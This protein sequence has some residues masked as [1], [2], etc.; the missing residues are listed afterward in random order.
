MIQKF[1]GLLIL[2][3]LGFVIGTSSVVVS[4]AQA[5]FYVSGNAGV[6]TL[7]DS[8]TKWDGDLGESTFNDGHV[9]TGA[10]GHTWGLFRVEGELSYRKNDWVVF[11]EEGLAYA[12]EGDFSSLSFMANVWRDFNTGT[13]YVPFVGGGIGISTMN[14]EI[15]KIENSPLSYDISDTVF[16]YQLGAGIGYKLT[17]KATINLSYRLFG[18]SE[19]ELVDSNNNDTYEYLNHSFMIGYRTTF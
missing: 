12:T 19:V 11:I 3:V 4:K 17:P 9:F 2:S 6:S 7:M 15:T 10:V 1:T 5:Q 14:M 8:D 13:N 16:A 18:T